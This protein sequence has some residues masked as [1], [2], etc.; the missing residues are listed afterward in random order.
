MLT[1]RRAVAGA[2]VSGAVLAVGRA[3]AE[4][5][6]KADLALVLAADGS[7]SIDPEEFKLQRQG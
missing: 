6:A 3:A 1:R 4:A 2:A 5:R 7:G